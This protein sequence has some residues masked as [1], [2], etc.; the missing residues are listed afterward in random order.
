[1]YASEDPMATCNTI[2]PQEN[3][4]DS[5][6]TDTLIPLTKN[7]TNAQF[8]VSYSDVCNSNHSSL[9]SSLAGIILFITIL[10]ANLCF[11]LLNG[12]NIDK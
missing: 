9:D 1:M 6:H 2:E 3:L 7:F 5:V 10:L 12:R 11:Q 4:S 8:D